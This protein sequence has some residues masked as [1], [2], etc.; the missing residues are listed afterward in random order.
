MQF[1]SST[2]IAITRAIGH[3]GLPVPWRAE[4]GS[5]KLIAIDTGA[6]VVKLN[7]EDGGVAV[8]TVRADAMMQDNESLHVYQSTKHIQVAGGGFQD[9]KASRILFVTSS[10]CFADSPIPN[11]TVQRLGWHRS[12]CLLRRP[13]L[14]VFKGVKGWSSTLASESCSMLH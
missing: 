2:E 4:P 10:G 5:L 11:V 8:A 12:R 13:R 7:P 14:L 3:D 6:G 9:I 1:I